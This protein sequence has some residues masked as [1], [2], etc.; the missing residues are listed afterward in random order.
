MFWRVV[1]AIYITLGL[2]FFVAGP[3][4]LAIGSVMVLSGAGAM[5][6][7][8]AKA[9]RDEARDMHNR[10]Q[11]LLPYIQRSQ[12]DMRRW[13]VWDVSGKSTTVEDL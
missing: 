4:G 10:R 11:D 7:W 13:P 3:V 1:I 2:V 8:R 9:D 5:V 6:W 12:L